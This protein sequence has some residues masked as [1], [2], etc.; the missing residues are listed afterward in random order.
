MLLAFLILTSTPVIIYNQKRRF[1]KNK[2]ESKVVVRMLHQVL[3][4]LDPN[5]ADELLLD[6]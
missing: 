4:F 6:D 3:Q 1:E 2:L 5:E